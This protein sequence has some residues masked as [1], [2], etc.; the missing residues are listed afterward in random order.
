MFLSL[1]CDSSS[2][3]NVYV[4]VYVCSF[5]EQQRA[6]MGITN[7]HSRVELGYIQISVV[8]SVEKFFSYFPPPSLIFSAHIYPLLIKG[9]LR[10]S[11]FGRLNLALCGLSEQRKRP[12]DTNFYSTPFSEPLEHGIGILIACFWGVRR[13][14]HK[15]Q[16]GLGP[17][18]RTKL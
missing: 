3:E 15:L 17:L 18:Q 1:H 7:Q 13:K 6:V 11:A 5:R 12:Q 14:K 9:I 10:G 4:C 2:Q 16:L 8:V